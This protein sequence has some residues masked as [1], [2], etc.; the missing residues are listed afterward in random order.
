MLEYIKQQLA[1]KR[2][3]IAESAQVFDNDPMDDAILEYAHLFDDMSELTM[4]GANQFR[5]RPIIDIPLDEDI[6][7]DSI[8]LSVTSNRVMDVPND[9]AAMEAC[10]DQQKTYEDFYNESYGSVTRLLRE[11]EDHYIDRVRDD[12]ETK[13]R[14]YMEYVIQEGLFGNDMISLNDDRVPR[15]ATI[16][17]GKY[18]SGDYIAKLPVAFEVYPGDK[19]NINQL[20]ALTIANN[21]E[22][23]SRIAEPLRNSIA[24]R[25]VTVKGAV[26]D[27]A[28]P[29][30]VILPKFDGTYKVVIKFEI[31]GTENLYLTWSIDEKHVRKSKNEALNMDSI[32]AS[33]IQRPLEKFDEKKIAKM[34]LMSKG[35]HVEESYHEPMRTPSRFGNQN[36]DYNYYQE[37]ID[38]GGG[39]NADA[40]PGGDGG[41]ATNDAPP[42]GNIDL[43]SE[44]SG[45]GGDSAD[46]NANA[47]KVDAD[48]QPAAVNDVSDAIAAK[49]SNETN[50]NPAD[51][52]MD[53]AP[54]FDAN[55]DVKLDLDNGTTNNATDSTEDVNNLEPDMS[56]DTSNDMGATDDFNTPDVT[57]NMDEVNKELDND[58]NSNDMNMNDDSFSGGSSMDN[59]DDMSIDDLLAKGEDKLKG[60]SIA[61]LKDFL[62]DGVGTDEGVNDTTLEY[63]NDNS[64]MNQIA[65]GVQKCLATLNND[66]PSAKQIVDDFGKESKKLNEVLSKASKNSS[67]KD[68]ERRMLDKLN[69]SLGELR[70]SFASDP[71]G[72]NKAKL[73][74]ALV[75]FVHDTKLVG[76]ICE[77]NGKK[78]TMEQAVQIPTDEHGN[79]ICNA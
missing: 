75:N 6:E 66:K 15:Y 62:N 70:M 18:N 74:N 26:W 14:A 73:K 64:C 29:T 10:Y 40:A 7:L 72:K 77:K 32:K 38:F 21:F 46:N 1:Q 63:A 24:E 13:Y 36:D 44:N 60:M 37:A 19:V 30:R 28:T 76:D 48:A 11:S 22:A 57:G 54:T 67:L 39:D 59:I 23:F 50:K 4:E 65:V 56:G 52:G 68:E 42:S 41:N 34:N 71:N 25:G 53:A 45:L 16:N 9:I 69:A 27:I 61:Q 8:E 49:V 33:D 35:H 20:H 47:P 17:F 43:G 55:P 2:E 5:E 51:L 12:A 31:E 58:T 3:Q 78:V 79:I